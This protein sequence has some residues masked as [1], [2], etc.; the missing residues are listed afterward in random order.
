MHLRLCSIHG[1]KGLV[2]EE[3]N[4]P[5]YV[6]PGR[7]VSVQPRIVP[8]Q[9]QKINYHE[10]KAR[11]SDQVGSHRHGKEF[12]HDIG[13]ERFQNI[14]RHQR[15]VHAG[16]LVLLQRWELF[17][18]NV[19]HGCGGYPKMREVLFRCLFCRKEAEYVCST[20]G[21]RELSGIGIGC[22]A[23]RVTLELLLFFL[24]ALE[25]PV[26]PDIIFPV[27]RAGAH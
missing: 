16:V 12:N 21:P 6:Y 20:I 23:R 17:L 15:V 7:A 19:N 11:E 9:S 5:R 13:V 26:W 14:S 3:T 18:P 8:K 4:S 22:D 25:G 2:Q 10:A 24:G 27:F 1:I